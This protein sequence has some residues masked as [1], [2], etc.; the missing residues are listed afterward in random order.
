HEL[1]SF[2]KNNPKNILQNPYIIPHNITQI[3]P[4]YFQ[5]IS[6][7][8]NLP[9]FFNKNNKNLQI[10]QHPLLTPT[11]PLQQHLNQQIPQPIPE[12]ISFLTPFIN[13]KQPSHKLL[14]HHY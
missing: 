6:Q 14:N 10:Q 8:F 11:H 2:L 12:H 7:H 3:L 9:P 13:K 4:T 5:T 1:I